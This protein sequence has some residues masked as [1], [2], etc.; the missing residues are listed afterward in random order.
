MGSELAAE[1]L[2]WLAAAF[3]GFSL[4]AAAVLAVHALSARGT[5][6]EGPSRLAFSLACLALSVAAASL[7]A[8]LILP[9]KPLLAERGL[10]V[11][12]VSCT[13]LGGLS[14][15]CPRWAGAPL[16]V[17]VFSALGLA[18]SETAA[19]HMLKPGSEVARLVPYQAT[20]SG[21]AGDLSVPDR[22]AVPVLSR[23]ALGGQACALEARVLELSGLPASLFGAQ[24]YVL[25]RL[26]DGAGAELLEFPRKPGPLAILLDRDDFSLAWIS[27]R[28][29]LS[30]SVPLVE[31]RALSWTF[32]ADGGLAVSLP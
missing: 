3:L 26:Q 28:T 20:A 18:A 7:A 31:L 15:V 24:R 2:G 12:A 21:I 13:A 27:V 32:G 17:L 1:S 29:V 4:G 11:W 16:A 19:W 14:A 6:R 30:R 22:N 25:V 9:P 23:V 5:G 8:L 10:W